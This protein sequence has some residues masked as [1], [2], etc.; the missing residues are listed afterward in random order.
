MTIDKTKLRPLPGDLETTDLTGLQNLHSDMLA[1]CS[2]VGHE[3]PDSAL[4][5][6]V[7]VPQG[8]RVIREL[9]A[10]ITKFLA[11]VDAPGKDL[12]SDDVK[13]ETGAS[14]EKPA[15]D[16]KKKK[17]AGKNRPAKEESVQDKMA[18]QKEARLARDATKPAETTPVA[19]PAKSEKENKMAKKAKKKSARKSAS[20]NA[21]TSVDETKKITWLLKEKEL[22]A[23]DGSERAERRKKLKSCAGKTVGAYLKGGG[24]VATLNRAVAEKV[25]KVS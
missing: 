4:V 15:P 10:G 1:T 16:K 6:I 22:G 23:R 18:R 12:A 7:G 3:P 24:S 17:K 25:I 2:D 11:G 19:A 5:E 9:H 14:A 20:N 8:L 21:R 13:S